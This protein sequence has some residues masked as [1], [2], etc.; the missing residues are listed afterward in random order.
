M[1]DEVAARFPFWTT[2]FLLVIGL[3]GMIG[4]RNLIKKVIGL[5]IFQSAIILFYISQSQKD[6]GTVPI[7]GDASAVD[8]ALY[9]NP[10]PH[11]LMLTAIVVSAAITGVALAFIV[12]IHRQ[13]HSL[14]EDTLP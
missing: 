11:V 6:G 5:S 12:M 9:M 8:P 4:K 1:I 2:A 13:F 14:D 7:L 3:Y 10:L